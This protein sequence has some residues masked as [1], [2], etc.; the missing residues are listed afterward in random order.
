METY[1]LIYYEGLMGIFFQWLYNGLVKDIIKAYPHIKVERRHWLSK[2][3]V[4]NPYAIVIGHS[5]GAN[6]ANR[7]TFKCKVLFTLDCR[8][9]FHGEYKSN[10]NKLGRG[11]HFNYYQ[12]SLGLPGYPIDGAINERV[13]SSHLGIVK[14]PVVYNGVMEVID[15]AMK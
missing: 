9:G 3:M 14:H 1:T 11:L 8:D 7:N 10:L 13:E 6:A 2:E 12:K 5:L 4:N 15:R